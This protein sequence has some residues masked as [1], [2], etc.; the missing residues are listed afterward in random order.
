MVSA[1]SLG[2]WAIGGLGWGEINDQESIAAV[3]AALGV[4]MAFVD[5][6]KTIAAKYGKALA[7]LAI[8][9]NLCQPG[10]TS[11]LTGAKRPD[12]VRENASGA[13]WRIR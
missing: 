13:G 1:V 2:I 11:G 7:Q 12:Q 5:R 9:W 4:G 10:V 6:L 8:N 3:Q